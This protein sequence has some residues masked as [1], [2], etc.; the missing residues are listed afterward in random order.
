MSKYIGGLEDI[1][2]FR[3]GFCFRLKSKTRI[4]W[5]VCADTLDVKLK[6]MKA[7]YSIMEKTEI[8][9]EGSG[10]SLVIAPEI[11]LPFNISGG[12]PPLP[13]S[14]PI[15]FSK[16]GSKN[17][18]KIIKIN[19]KIIKKNRCHKWEMGDFA[20]LESMYTSLRW[21]EAISAKNVRATPKWRET[22][23]R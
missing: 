18:Q 15:M 3:E 16:N 1:G 17:G 8:K 19:K 22:L 23:R 9:V 20:G 7:I 6:W 12:A 4:V 2:N 5:N 10:E 11:K 13:E 21:R 14:G